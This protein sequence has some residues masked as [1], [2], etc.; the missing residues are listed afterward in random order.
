MYAAY[1]MYLRVN[2]LTDMEINTLKKEV[3]NHELSRASV[4]P[5][6]EPSSFFTFKSMKLL[7]MLISKNCVSKNI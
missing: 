7:K 4:M 1:K 3:S 5:L 6:N 2:K